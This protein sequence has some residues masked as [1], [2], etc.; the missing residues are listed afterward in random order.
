MAQDA[1]GDEI[2]ILS[3]SIEEFGD[4]I[5][6]KLYRLDKAIDTF[7]DFEIDPTVT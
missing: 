7:P 4:K 5:L 3:C 1:R 6:S 2:M